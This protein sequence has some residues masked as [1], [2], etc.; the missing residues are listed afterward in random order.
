MDI[1]IA[2]HD[3]LRALA[4][5]LWLH[6]SPEE[7]AAQPLEAFTD[8]LAMWWS[9]H[10]DSHHAFVAWTAGREP[11]GMAWLALLPRVPRPGTA[12]RQSADIQSVFVMP[13]HRGAGTGSAL[14]RTATSH[15]FAAGATRV[16][17]RSGR[18]AVPVYR[19]LGFEASDRLLQRSA[20][21]GPVA[22]W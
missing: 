4:G 19:R 1:S 22:G 7:Q 15:A 5:L 13:E 10:A 11:I 6:A 21:D 17:V 2:G 12:V 18:R 14:V 9:D 20:D 16:T 8:D 3:D